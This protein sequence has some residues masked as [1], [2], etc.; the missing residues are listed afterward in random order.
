MSCT[1]DLYQ[2][3]VVDL[4]RHG[5]HPPIYAWTDITYLLTEAG[6]DWAYYV[7]DDTCLNPDSFC[8]K[9]DDSTTAAQ[10]PLTAVTTR[11]A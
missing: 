5:E 7:G 8:R 4:Q 2:D 3:G 9:S 11:S 10:N 6:V 1:S